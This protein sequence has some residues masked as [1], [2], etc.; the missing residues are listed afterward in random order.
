[1]HFFVVAVY[2][3]REK[4]IPGIDTYPERADYAH[5]C[6]REDATGIAIVGDDWCGGAPED[7]TLLRDLRWVVHELNR[8]ALLLRGLPSTGS[9]SAWR[10]TLHAYMASL[11]AG[12]LCTACRE[13][14]ADAGYPDREGL[15]LA[16]RLE[17]HW[18]QTRRASGASNA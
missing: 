11:P 3:A 6:L 12:D 4:G 9:P 10:D 5:V 15:I 14:L 2:E 17:R 16:A 18:L 1:M 7:R 8:V 13:A